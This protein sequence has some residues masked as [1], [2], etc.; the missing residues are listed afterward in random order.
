MN[1]FAYME[2]I[3]PGI[4]M[5]SIINNYYSNHSTAFKLKLTRVPPLDIFS[6]FTGSPIR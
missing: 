2:F 6:I 5:M 1:G 4:I 3:A